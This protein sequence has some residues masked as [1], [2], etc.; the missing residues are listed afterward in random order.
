[1]AR[2]GSSF[3]LIPEG[4]RYVRR[5]DGTLAR[6]KKASKG[7]RRHVFERDN[8]TCQICGY[9]AP[10][11]VEPWERRTD[12]LELGHLVPYRDGGPYHVDNLQVECVTCNRRK[13]AGR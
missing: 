2:N 9:R 12:G 6:T 11:P 8:F 7:V 10:D 1:M 13:G 3:D 5:P 4:K